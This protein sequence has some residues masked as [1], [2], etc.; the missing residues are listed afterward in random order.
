MN[1]LVIRGGGSF[2]LLFYSFFTLSSVLKQPDSE[3]YIGIENSR[4]RPPPLLFSRSLL[5][6]PGTSPRHATRAPKGS[7][8]E[9]SHNGKTGG[10]GKGRRCGEKARGTRRAESGPTVLL[11]APQFCNVREWPRGRRPSSRYGMFA[12]SARVSPVRRTP[13][14]LPRTLC[15]GRAAHIVVVGS[16]A[17]GAARRGRRGRAP[18]S[19]PP[20]APPK[21]P[22]L[23]REARRHNPSPGTDR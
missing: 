11:C 21:P 1:W 12:T 6:V 14:P 8:A 13:I 7:K 5:S 17:R 3:L 20:R 18:S 15:G 16:F 19:P 9:P 22:A 4:P 10:A 23:P 2:L